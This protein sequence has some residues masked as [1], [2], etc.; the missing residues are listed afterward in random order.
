M[1][2]TALRLISPLHN[3]EGAGGAPIIC[4]DTDFNASLEIVKILIQHA[5]K[6]YDALPAEITPPINNN[7]KL[8]LLQTLPDQFDRAKYI[9]IATQL[10]IPENCD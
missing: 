1:I 7:P 8:A 2:L 9:E 10:Q 4:S 3:G 6:V 5:A